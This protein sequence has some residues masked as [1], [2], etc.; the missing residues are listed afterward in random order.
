[1]AG[2]L[3][4][5]RDLD[6]YCS[7]YL[8]YCAEIP[9]QE[10]RALASYERYLNAERERA[11]AALTEALQSVR[12]EALIT[13]FSAALG[14]HGPPEQPSDEQAIRRAGET[15]IKTSKS[16]LLKRGRRIGRGAR[17]EELH[18]LRKQ[19]KRFRY[20]LESLE[21]AFGDSL[22]PARKA[23]IRLQEE[24]GAYQDAS[25]ATQRLMA[26]AEL[27]PVE[28]ASRG[29]L[30]ALGQLIGGQDRRAKKAR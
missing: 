26:Y 12:Y 14:V 27:L 29:E 18:A 23:S 10:A 6:V 5:V 20:L 28:A 22:T 3:G 24:L 21:E 17:P 8:V 7:Q 19:T 13:N 16:R 11:A 15:Y 1:L 4:N 9:K 2:V 25:T 30:L